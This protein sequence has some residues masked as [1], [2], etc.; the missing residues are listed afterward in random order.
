[1]PETDNRDK[2]MPNC[3]MLVAKLL[4][5]MLPL[6]HIA[7]STGFVSRPLSR[8]RL[9]IIQKEPLTA[10]TTTTTPVSNDSSPLRFHLTTQ[11]SY[12]RYDSLVAG[13]AEISI[14]TSLGVLMSEASV[15]LTGCGPA[16]MSDW[17]ERFCYQ[18]VIFFAGILLF[19]RIAFGKDVT[20]LIEEWEALPVP[21]DKITTVQ[22]R[23]AEILAFL[24]VAGAI[25]VLVNQV[26]S[27]QNMDGLS[28]IDVQ[29]CQSMRDFKGLYE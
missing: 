22:A 21:L 6:L 27:G 4:S 12:S 24:S 10:T 26:A 13:I 2:A 29:M 19:V 3:N 9:Q 18:G 15:L 11:L 25:L 1:M 23:G 28:G 14:G 5:F 16:G 17:L 7:S 8:R 20:T